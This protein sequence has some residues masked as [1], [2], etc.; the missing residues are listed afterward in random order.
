[1]YSFEYNTY[2]Q[3]KTIRRYSPNIANPVS[4]PGDYFQRAYITYNLPADSSSPQTDCPRF[5]TRTDWAHEWN[6][7]AVTSTFGPATPTFS[8]GEVTY[9]DGTLYKE[10]YATTGWQRGLTTQ[11]ETWS[12]GVKKKWTAAQWTQDNTGLSYRLNPR[13]IETNVYDDSGNQRRTTIEYTSYGLPRDVYEY[14]AAPNTSRVLRRSHI[15]Y[16]LNSIYTSR[17]IIGLP[18]AQF[19]YDGN[20]YI[21]S[22]GT[23]NNPGE[24][25]AS[26]ITYDYDLGGSFQV[27]QGPPIRHDTTNYGSG[28]VQGRGNLNTVRRWD[29]TDSG[30]IS[31][32]TTFN[33]GFNTSGSV[34]FKQDSL[35]HQANISYTD[36][37]SDLVNRNTLA[38]P[39]TATDPDNYS[40]TIQ[41]N[42]DFGAVTRAQDP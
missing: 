18:S 2:G 40:S 5:T 13:V 4:F 34:I 23:Y 1:I 10:F 30:N 20:G 36:S 37:F 19:V 31:K 25:L 6:P 41:Y 38:Y 17:R 22:G 24:I 26:K 29:V 39:T 9:P 32:S 21:Y 11:T 3:V 33:T 12:G 14:D 8:Y 15:D 28:F 16:N 27:H 42:F 7:G 35:N